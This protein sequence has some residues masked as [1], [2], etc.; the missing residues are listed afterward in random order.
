MNSDGDFLCWLQTTNLLKP[1]LHWKPEML[2]FRQS[3][4]DWRQKISSSL[5]KLTQG[6]FF[7]VLVVEITWE[8]N[9]SP[10][11]RSRMSYGITGKAK[12]FPS[13][14]CNVYGAAYNRVLKSSS[15]GQLELCPRLRMRLF[16]KETAP[17]LQHKWQK[18]LH[19]K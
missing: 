10:T 15:F 19:I 1:V 18:G 6:K 3:L 16:W 14:A 5:S 2:N 4:I 8:L 13:A 11:A 7:I 9:T 17:R 12:S